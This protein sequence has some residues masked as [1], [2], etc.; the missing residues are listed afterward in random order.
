M[1]TSMIAAAMLAGSAMA[2]NW[3]AKDNK[4]HYKGDPVVLHGFSTTCTEYL[5]RGVGM[6]CW[7]TYNWRDPS[8]VISH[9]LNM[10]QVDALTGYFK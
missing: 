9:S 2:G 10:P 4:L 5:L 7:A 3:E 6:K 8:S 1:R